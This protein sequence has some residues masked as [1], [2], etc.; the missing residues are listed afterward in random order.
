[1]ARPDVQMPS[2]EFQVPAK[3]VGHRPSA[4]GSS[5]GRRGLTLLEALASLAILGGVVVGV[6]TARQRAQEACRRAQET[7]VGAR[8]CA[9]LAARLRA[10]E[11]GAAEGAADEAGYAWTIAPDALPADAPKGLEAFR[12]RVT[13]P[14]GEENAEATVWRLAEN[15]GVTP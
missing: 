11:L 9:S 2:P 14:S 15:A 3:G 10:G 1:M 8:L 7:L 12:V 5:S 4:V 13:P 6:L